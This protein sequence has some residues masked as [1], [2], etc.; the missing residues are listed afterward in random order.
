MSSH[1]RGMACISAGRRS[2]HSRHEQSWLGFATCTVQV[3]FVG[4]LAYICCCVCAG[5][6]KQ[7]PTQALR[8]MF[9]THIRRA[10]RT[11][12]CVCVTPGECVRA[13]VRVC[14]SV[15]ACARADPPASPVRFF[16][17]SSRAMEKSTGRSLRLSSSLPTCSIERGLLP[18]LYGP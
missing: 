17:R 3:V 5:G 7:P 1:G 13:C 11:R 2:M 16:T 10:A 18:L 9:L 4:L 6:C 12:G 14:V 15:R 8:H